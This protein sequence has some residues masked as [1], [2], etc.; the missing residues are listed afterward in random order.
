MNIDFK[1]YSEIRE[2]SAFHVINYLNSFELSNIF[3]KYGDERHS[4]KIADAIV[5]YRSM[6]GPISTTHQLAEL[7]VRCVGR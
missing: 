1:I 4:R 7:V 3:K 5:E 6:I 2:I